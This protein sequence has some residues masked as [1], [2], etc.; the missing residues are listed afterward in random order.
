MWNLAG[1]PNDE[2]S[3]ENGII[4]QNSTRWPYLIDPEKQAFKFLRNLSKGVKDGVE[5]SKAKNQ[6]FMK[7][8]EISLQAGKWMIVE[9]C[10]ESLDVSLEP[11]LQ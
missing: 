5:F 11:I 9:D 10:A 4:I 3:I 7:T 2:T 1:L 8:L 6:N